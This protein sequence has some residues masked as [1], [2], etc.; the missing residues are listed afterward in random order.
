MKR[1]IFSYPRYQKIALDIANA[2]YKG[3]IKEGERLH[4]R[5]TLAGRYGVSPETIRRAIKLLEDVKVVQSTKGSGINVLSKDNAF[6]YINKFRHIDSISTY[7]STL[8]AL[9]AKKIEIDK[10]IV[11]TINKIVDYSS[12]LSNINPITPMEIEIPKS[13]KIV[14][15]SI[16]DVKFW[17]HTG[18]TIIGIR[19]DGAIMLSPGPYTTFLQDDILLVIGEEHVYNAVKSFLNEK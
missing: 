6:D 16:S 5:S 10:E 18:A 7:K 11:K 14:G 17:Q 9:I 8:N 4:G 3:D 2:I 13:S 15:Q 12:K 1:E 19:R